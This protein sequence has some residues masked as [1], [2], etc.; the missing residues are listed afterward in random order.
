MYLHIMEFQCKHTFPPHAMYARPCDEI[1]NAPTFCP[2]VGSSDDS[3]DYLLVQRVV[4]FWH[5]TC[6]RSAQSHSGQSQ[7]KALRS[8]A[9][10]DY[11]VD[12]SFWILDLNM[13]YT[14]RNSLLYIPCNS[15]PTYNVVRR[16]GFDEERAK[17]MVQVGEAPEK[18]LM[19]FSVVCLYTKCIPYLG[20]SHSS[21][22]SVG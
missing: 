13:L 18:A 20:L 5:V 8:R 12:M 17:I 21:W 6:C 15:W 10:F 14:R 7:E 1:C 19:C 16:N 9:G 22:I 4:A 11:F 2:Q 3:G